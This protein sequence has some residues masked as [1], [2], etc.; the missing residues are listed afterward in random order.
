MKL[1]LKL[2][3]PNADQEAVWLNDRIKEY[4]IDGLKT[5]VEEAPTERGVMSGGLL[6]GAL[7][8]V[9]EESI[10]K[11]IE[12]VFDVTFNHFDGKK[13]AFELSGECSNSGKKFTLKFENITKEQQ[14][15]AIK[16]FN[17]HYKAICG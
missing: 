12:K 15:K 2:N 16:E 17:E 6:L 1:Q 9:M 7:T 13:A 4:D 14:Q 10:K 5:E 11:I 8:L 3:M